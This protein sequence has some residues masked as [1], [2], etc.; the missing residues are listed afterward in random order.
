MKKML[1]DLADEFGVTD[2]AALG[3]AVSALI[4]ANANEVRLRLEAQE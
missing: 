1:N 2:I 4:R 3:H